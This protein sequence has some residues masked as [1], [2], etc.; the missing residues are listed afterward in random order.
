M[1]AH[2]HVRHDDGIF[3][4]RI[5]IDVHPGE[6][7]GAA[8]CGA[9]YDASSRDKRSHRL[10]APLLLIVNKFGGRRDLRMGPDRPCAVVNIELGDDVGEV[11]VGGPVGIHGSHVPPIGPWVVVGSDAGGGELVRHR[12]AILYDVRNHVLA[13]IMARIRVVR[14]TPQLVEQ[15][16]RIEYIDPH[17]GQ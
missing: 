13:E 5:R 7:Q 11:N 4:V 8:Q 17:A 12:P 9:G 3:H 2:A 15:E 16:F 10:S 1:P 14:V 6:K